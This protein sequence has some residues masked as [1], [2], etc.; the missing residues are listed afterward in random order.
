MF[1]KNNIFHKFKSMYKTNKTNR[2]FKKVSRLSKKYQKCLLHCLYLSFRQ[3]DL[4][5]IP[6]TEEDI[7]ELRNVI[8]EYDETIKKLNSFT[9]YARIYIEENTDNLTSEENKPNE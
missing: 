9:K 8:D 4:I 7:N 5:G 1:N 6:Y 3:I 2:M